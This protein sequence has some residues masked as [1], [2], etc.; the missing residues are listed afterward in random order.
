MAIFAHDVDFDYTQP[1]ESIDLLNDCKS[2]AQ[3]QTAC[4]ANPEV[5]PNITGCSEGVLE[6]IVFDQQFYHRQSMLVGTK[7]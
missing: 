3:I 6:Q 2:I 5:L 1:N 4:R 7:H